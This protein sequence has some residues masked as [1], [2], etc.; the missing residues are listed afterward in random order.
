MSG[1]LRGLAAASVDLDDI[2]CYYHIH[3]LGEPPAALRGL[4]LTR[5]LPRFVE[6]FAECEMQATFF[7]VGATVD[8]QT[9]GNVVKAHRAG[10][11]LGNHSMT[12]SYALAKSS[13][14]F[15]VSELL[16]CNRVLSDVTGAPT[17]G[18]RAP[19]YDVSPALAKAVQQVGFAYSSSMLP[20]PAYYAAKT[21]VMAWHALRGTPSGA[22]RTEPRA[23]LAPIDP[24]RMSLEAPWRRGASTLVELPMAVTSLARVPV[25]GTSVLLAPAWLRRTL[26][27]SMCGRFFNFEM[28]GLD[29]ADAAADELP[30]ELVARQPDLRIPLAE[31]RARL[32]EVLLLAKQQARF[33]RLDAA[34]QLVV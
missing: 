20:A 2:D 22:V 17:V 31:K 18:F 14:A 23:L 33:V 24:Y 3:A 21:G 4:A 25:I 12:H 9:L 5:W 13:P 6:L 26:V 7:V 8:A 15:I 30:A 32:R 29:L 10:H 19:G 1:D 11:E 16:R 27:R 34:A 28:H